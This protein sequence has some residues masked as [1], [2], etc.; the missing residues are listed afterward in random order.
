MIHSEAN[1]VKSIFLLYY[2]IHYCFVAFE[3]LFFKLLS[4]PYNNFKNFY[5][6]IQQT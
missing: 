4:I 3:K 6:N 1:G 2:M 5:L